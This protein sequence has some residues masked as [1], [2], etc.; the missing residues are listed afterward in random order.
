ME[1]ELEEFNQTL[2]NLYFKNMNFLKDN[3]PKI[4]EKVDK[5]SENINNETHKEKYSLEYKPEG[6]FDI[7]NNETN[8]FVYGFDSYAEADKRTEMSNFTKQHSLDLLR[9]EP[10]T[11]KFAL[12]GSLGQIANLVH[13]LNQKIDFEN[14][15][16]SKIY[17]YIFIGVGV[18]VH[19]HEVYKKI[20]SMNTL[21]IEPDLELFRI[22]LFT[23]DYSVF[24]VGNKKLF[25]SV[26]ENLLQMESTLSQFTS[27]HSYMNYNIKHHLFWIDY[28]YILDEIISYY[29]H[30][31][32]AAFSYNS[33]LTVF[34]RTIEFMNN[35][36]KFLQ[37]DL[38]TKTHPLKDKKVLIVSGGPSVD[39]HIDWIYENQDKFIIV[40]VDVALK[41]LEKHKVVPDIVVSIDPSDL[42]AKFFETEDKDFLKDSA[43]IFLSQ[44]EQTVLDTVRHL[45]VYFSQVY[46][47]SKKIGYA[48]SLANVGTFSLAM[49]LLLDANELYLVGSDAAFHQE[50]GSR[51]AKHSGHEM[52]DQHLLE[53]EE[54]ESESNLVS[55]TDVIEVKG[56][57]REIVKTNRD[58]VTFK[59][60]YETFIH[61][62]KNEKEFTAYNISDGAYIEGLIPLEAS[63]IDIENFKPKDFSAKEVIDSISITD[64]D[65]I[66]FEKDIKTLTRIIKRVNKFKK[67]KITSKNNFLE[68]KLDIMIWILEQNKIM[69]H[70]IFGNIFLKYIELIDIYIN[71]TLNLEQR[72]LNTP[73]NLADIRN[74]WADSLISL[75]KN[76]KK[77][78]DK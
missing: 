1:E 46:Y 76:I 11:N 59:K 74:H 8:E 34:S 51:Y 26:G 32:A 41:K 61:N 31:H 15:T 27:Y 54:E 24:E 30:N 5:L 53:E 38:I 35:K 66:N 44:Q 9:V 17:K 77:A 68:N 57:L 28:K 39:D 14:I 65:D 67:T 33:I 12:M 50:T 4:Y 10:S 40:C 60:D 49:A 64:I 36:E 25:L 13:Y 23:V 22:S 3:F 70:A 58:L 47:I 19:I 29:S 55:F 71:F 75:L 73:K 37:K 52:T 56:N 43:I 16:F 42:V 78:I 62:V 72:E 63:D 6:Y 20:N 18:G 69:E 21:I 45:N 7:L 48:V 2:V